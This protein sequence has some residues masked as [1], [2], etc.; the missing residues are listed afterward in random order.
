[1]SRRIVPAIA[2]VLIL[3]Y[4]PTNAFA[5]DGEAIEARSTLKWNE[6]TVDSVITL[7]AKKAGLTMPTGRTAALESIETAMPSLLGNTLF[8]IPLNS[9]ERLGDAV[10]KGT[11]SLADIYRIIDA[12]K[13]TPPTFSLDLESISMAHSLSLAQIG[14]LFIAHTVANGAKPPLQVVPTRAYTGILIDARGKLP[15]HG[16]YASS[17]VWPCLFPRIWDVGM[18][19]LYEKNSV[20]PVVA[21]GRGI[22]YYASA[23]D[24]DASRARIGPDPLRI[25]AREVYG[26]NRTDPVISREDYLRVMSIPE[27]RAL[28][29]AGKVVILVD[30]E[31]L[32]NT[33]LG[34]VKDDEYYFVKREIDRALCSKPAGGMDFTDGWEGLKLTAYDIRFIADTAEIVPAEKQRIDAIADA[35]RLAGPLATFSVDGH[36]ASVGKPGGEMT[37]SVERAAKIA[38][39]LAK[40]GIS[41]DRIKAAGFGGTRPIASNDTDEGRARNR[42]V[43]ITITLAA[44]QR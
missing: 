26:N 2:F 37:L 32:E 1:M 11:V 40:R 5:Q 28:L 24:D 35:L 13:K 4:F 33:N 9:S 23:I 18:N 10:A 41:R 22:A 6:E 3:A 17:G 29:L 8:S 36:T 15:I 12:G 31:S 27:N 38:D 30:G 20:D 16:E 7:N 39:E 34:P 19:L 43:E 25:A 44:S 42:R 14:S 21:K